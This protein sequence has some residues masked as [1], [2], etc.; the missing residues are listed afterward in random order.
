MAAEVDHLGQEAAATWG[1]LGGHHVLALGG[2]H[3]QDPLVLEGL[4][5]QDRHVLAGLRAQDLRVLAGLLVGAVLVQSGILAQ[6]RLVVVEGGPRQ[7]LV[8]VVGTLWCQ[9]HQELLAARVVVQ[10]VQRQTHVLVGKMMVHCCR[11]GPLNPAG[12]VGTQ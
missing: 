3:A 10:T 5:A 9:N 4:R 12:P 8:P 7:T 2:L 1:D 11:V 6:H